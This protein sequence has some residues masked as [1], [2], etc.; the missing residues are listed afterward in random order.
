MHGYE[1]HFGIKS[2]IKFMFFAGKTQEDEPL[3][4]SHFILDYSSRGTG[5]WD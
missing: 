4:L 2:P 1:V 3:L 5:V